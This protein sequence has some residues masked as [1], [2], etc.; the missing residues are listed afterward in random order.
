MGVNER[1]K[2][3]PATCASYW[4]KYAVVAEVPTRTEPRRR[5]STSRYFILRFFGISA[6]TKGILIKPSFYQA[7][8]FVLSTN[9]K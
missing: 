4:L 1:R 7:R 6:K 8:T 3:Y 9:R 2:G 5:T